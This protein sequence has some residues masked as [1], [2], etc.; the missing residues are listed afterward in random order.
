MKN[1]S[2]VLIFTS[3]GR[4]PVG[5][6]ISEVC[7]CDASAKGNLRLPFQLHL[8][9]IKSYCLV[10]EGTN[11]RTTCLVSESGTAGN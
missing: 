8:T 10:T 11:M 7:E 5:K 9:G 1:V 4:V 3:L 6:L 2:K